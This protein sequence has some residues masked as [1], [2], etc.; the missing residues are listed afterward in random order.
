[1]EFRREFCDLLDN[2]CDGEVDESCSCI[3]TVRESCY[4]GPAGTEGVGRCKAG[5]WLCSKVST[6][7]HLD[8]VLLEE[9]N[10]IDDNCNG[11]IDEGLKN[12]CGECGPQPEES[13]QGPT[14]DYGNGLDDDCDGQI[15]ETCNCNDRLN[16]PCYSGLPIR[17]EGDLC[18]ESSTVLMAASPSVAAKCCRRRLMPAAMGSTATVTAESTRLS[19]SELQNQC[20]RHATESTTT[21]T[22]EST[23]VCEDHGCIEADAEEICGYGFDNDCDGVLKKSVDVRRA[24][25]AVLWRHPRLSALDSVERAGLNVFRRTGQRGLRMP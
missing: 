9:C 18:R 2:D 13:C 21:A 7:C 24:A 25:A 23:K 5:F 8:D 14:N 12:R 10:G 16:Q 20:L 3:A 22:A 6:I 15:D 11:E 19:S 17:W 1:M 4:E